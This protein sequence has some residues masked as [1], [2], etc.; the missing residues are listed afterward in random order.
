MKS[1]HHRAWQVVSTQDMQLSPSPS[2]FNA[3]AAELSYSWLPSL[4]LAGASI[5]LDAKS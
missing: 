1:T 5:A 2:S 4:I 3:E